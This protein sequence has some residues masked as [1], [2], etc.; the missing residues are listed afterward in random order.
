MGGRGRPILVS[1]FMASLVYIEFQDSHID[2]VKPCPKNKETSK[3]THT[4]ET[5]TTRISERILFLSFIVS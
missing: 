2:I 5:M 4:L 3:Q 1:E